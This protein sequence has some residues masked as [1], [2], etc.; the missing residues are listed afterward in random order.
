MG[1]SA[2]VLMRNLYWH[3]AAMLVLITRLGSS[4]FRVHLW[5]V[6]KFDLE[7]NGHFTVREQLLTLVVFANPVRF[8]FIQTPDYVHIMHLYKL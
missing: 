1:F 7:T 3:I 5:S 4:V 8:T 2:T 6:R